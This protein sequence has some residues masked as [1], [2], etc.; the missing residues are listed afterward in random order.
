VSILGN[1]TS[2]GNHSLNLFAGELEGIDLAISLPGQIQGTD[3]LIIRTEIL[4]SSLT[5]GILDLGFGRDGRQIGTDSS[6]DCLTG[7]LQGGDFGNFLVHG[8]LF[9]IF[10]FGS[11]LTYMIIIINFGKK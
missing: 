6:L 5:N 11:G 9:V 3:E 8:N 1:E 10:Y 4:G 2:L 7:K